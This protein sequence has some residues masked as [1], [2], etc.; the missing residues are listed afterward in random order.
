MR[1]AVASLLDIGKAEQRPFDM[2][3]GLAADPD[4]AR[5]IPAHMYTLLAAETGALRG[6]A[7][8]S[9]RSWERDMALLETATGASC[10]NILLQS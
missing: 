9:L 5:V 8:P 1:E 10:C 3:A 6:R 4:L 7:R 2:V